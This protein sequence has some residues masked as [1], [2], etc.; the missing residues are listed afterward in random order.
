[1]AIVRGWGKVSIQASSAPGRFQISMAR[2]FHYR[3]RVDAIPNPG[4]DARTPE[5]VE[6]DFMA[7]ALTLHTGNAVWTPATLYCLVV[8]G[9]PAGC[10]RHG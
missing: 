10:A 9:G 1:M 5:F 2:V 4:R 8:A 7:A 3:A 6:L